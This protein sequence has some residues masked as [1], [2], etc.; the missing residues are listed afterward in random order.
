MCTMYWET[1]DKVNLLGIGLIKKDLVNCWKEKPH[2]GIR[3][4]RTVV[5]V[6]YQTIR[7]QS[8]VY[9]AQIYFHKF[10]LLKVLCME[11][12][13]HWYKDL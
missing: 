4:S 1:G 7:G 6:D 2:Y 8:T 13:G 10:G 9:N 11:Y 3:V 12:C 5:P